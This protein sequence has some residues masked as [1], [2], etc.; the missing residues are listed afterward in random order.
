M[1]E[2]FCKTSNIGQEYLRLKFDC[3]NT[4]TIRAGVERIQ[5]LLDSHTRQCFNCTT[6]EVEYCVDIS[7]NR[8]M[9]AV[10]DLG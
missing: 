10:I 3:H 6:A 9:T 8:D 5:E 7:F 4:V 2:V 1:P